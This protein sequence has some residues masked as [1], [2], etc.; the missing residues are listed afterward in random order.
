MYF[1]K[2]V[3]TPPYPSAI[4]Q[5]HRD[6]KSRG[7]EPDYELFITDTCHYKLY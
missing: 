6:V 7:K 1:L 2:K 4:I 3:K 5:S